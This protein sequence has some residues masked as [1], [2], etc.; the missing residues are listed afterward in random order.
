MTIAMRARASG[1]GRSAMS[2]A[3]VVWK[4]PHSRRQAMALDTFDPF[5]AEEAVRLHEQDQ[6]EEYER[7]DVAHPAP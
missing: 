7:R 6:D 5:L 1:V 2:A 4:V 3:Y